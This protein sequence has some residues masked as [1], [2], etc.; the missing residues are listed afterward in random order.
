[1]SDMKSPAAWRAD[2]ASEALCLTAE[3]LKH[4]Q[5]AIIFQAREAQK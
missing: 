5:I 2:R 4:S 1:M 3:R